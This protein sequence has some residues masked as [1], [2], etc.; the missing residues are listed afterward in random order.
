LNGRYASG[1]G[2]QFSVH[3]APFFAFSFGWH[4]DIR[5][6]QCWRLTTQPKHL[7]HGDPGSDRSIAQIGFA[8]RIL[9][10]TGAKFSD[11]GQH[12]GETLFSL[13]YRY[14]L[15]ARRLLGIAASDRQPQRLVDATVSKTLT[16]TPSVDF[17]IPGN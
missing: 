6:L 10:A 17:D 15:S 16:I 11:V 5:Y 8:D 4:D 2:V 3:L 9:H 14:S 13:G 7:V 12:R 1:D